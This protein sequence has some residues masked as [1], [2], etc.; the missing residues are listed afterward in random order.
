MDLEG[1]LKKDLSKLLEF[2]KTSYSKICKS[3]FIFKA[4]KPNSSLVT[5]VVEKEFLKLK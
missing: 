2:E 5:N 4:W 3:L 1:R